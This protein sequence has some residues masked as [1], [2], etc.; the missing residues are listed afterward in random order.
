MLVLGMCICAKLVCVG[1]CSRIARRSG[2][3]VA[4]TLCVDHIL[5]SLSNCF[6]VVVLCT[7]YFCNGLL[8]SLEY[9]LDDVCCIILSSYVLVNWALIVRT[10]L[11]MLAGHA[12]DP[13]LS[14][15]I[16]RSAAIL[17]ENFP[18]V[19]AKVDLLRLFHIGKNLMAEVELQ[20]SCGE[21][22][23]V[24]QLVQHL[25]YTLAHDSCAS[26]ERVLVTLRVDSKSKEFIEDGIP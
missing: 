7:L 12:A 3:D 17:V 26:I 22:Q 13:D 21:I 14:Q 23:A 10:E 24:A 6:V 9:Y 8:G 18:H 16:V 4:K 19:D 5:D 25:E 20:V 15:R 1:F 11:K 2:S